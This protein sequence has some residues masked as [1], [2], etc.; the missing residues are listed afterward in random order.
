MMTCVLSAGRNLLLGGWLVCALALPWSG[1]AGIQDAGGNL[2]GGGNW[3]YTIDPNATGVVI[4]EIM[5][6]PASENVLEEYIEL[7]NRGAAAVDLTGWRFSS[8]V[9]F[10]FPNLTIAPGGYLV[11][12]ADLPTFRAKYPTVSNV[13]GGWTGNL[14]NTRE[15]IDLDDATGERIDSVVYADEGDWGER[16]LDAP[17]RGVR[18]WIWTAAHDGEGN[19]AE[20]LNPDLSNDSGQNWAPSLV[21]EGT[22]GRSN[23]VHTNNIPPLLL[24]VRHFPAVPRSTQDVIVTGRVVDETVAGTTVKLQHRVDNPSPVPFSTMLMTDDGTGAD[25]SAGDGVYTAR[26]PAQPTGTVVEFYLEATDGEGRLRLWPASARDIDGTSLGPVAN[27]LYQ[28]DDSTQ[29]EFQGRQ[30][31]YK[32]IMTEIER[33]RLA[34]IPGISTL[35]GP[36]SQMN[37]TFISLDATGTDVRYLA[38]FRNRGHGTR[39]ADPPNY[40]VNFRSDHLWKGVEALNLN[41]RQVHAQHF[42]SAL[43][44]QAGAAGPACVAVQVRVNNANRAV[45]GSPMFG[46]YAA[47]EVIAGDWAERHVPGDDDGNVYR[48]VRDIAPPDFDYRTLEAYPG[49]AGPEDPSSYTHTWIKETNVSEDDWTDLIGM[50]RVLG[51]NGITPFTTENVRQVID[52]E[53]WVRH[54]AVMNLLGN[55]ETG[56]NS[57]YNDDYYFYRGKQDPRFI[58]LFWD[59]DQILG[60]TSFAPDASIFSATADNGAGLALDRLLHWPDFEPLYYRTLQDL[61]DGPFSAAEFHALIEQTLGDYVPSATR[62][63]MENWMASRRAVVQAAIDGLVPPVTVAPL[64]RLSGVPRSPTPLTSA[65]ITVQGTGVT[66]YRFQLDGAPYG[67]ETAVTQPIQLS[68]L[69]PGTHTLAVVARTADGLWQSMTQATTRTWGVNPAWPSVRLNEVLARNDSALDHAGTSPDVVELYNEGSSTVDLAGLRLSDNPANPGKFTFPTGTTLAPGAY[70]VVFAN[71]PDGTPGFHLG[72]GLSESGEGLYLYHR[73]SNGGGLLDA[74]EFGPQITDV[75]IGRIG[76]GG[77]WLLTQPTPGTANQTQPLGEPHRLRINE[78]LAYGQVSFPDD[79]VEL[80]NPESLPVAL[81]GLFLTDEPNGAPMRHRIADLSFIDAGGFRAFVADGE[82]NDG[83]DHLGFRLAAE[84]GELALFDPALQRIDSIVYGPQSL[85][86]SMGRCPD[87]GLNRRILVTPTP[88]APNL[89]PSDPLPP[90]RVT[91][92]AMA[93]TWRFDASGADQGTAWREPGFDDGAWPEGAGLLARESCGCLPEPILTELTFTSP[94]QITFYFRTHFALPP[95]LGASALDITHL[96]DDGAIFYLNGTEIG[97]VNMPPGEVNFQTQASRGVGNATYGGPLNVPLALIQPRDNVLAVEVHQDDTA[98]T[99]LVFGARLDALAVTNTPGW[100]SIVINEVLANNASWEEPDRSLPDWVEILNLSS[101]SVDLADASLTDAASEPRRWVFPPRSVVP[102]FGYLKVRC[103]GAAPTSATNTGFGLRAEGGS[104]YLF[105]RPIDGGQLLDSITYGLQPADWS[106]GRIPDG[107]SNWTL[108]QPTFGAANLAA[109]LAS[110]P[111]PKINEWMAAPDA[112]DDWF[113]I[114]NP[115]PQPMDL[116]GLHLTDRL[117]QPDLHRLPPLSFLG[118]GV[119]G[120]QRFIA[121]GNT[122]AGAHHVGFALNRAGDSLGLATGDATAYLDTIAFGPQQTSVSQ[123]RFP[124]GTATIVSFPNSATPGR[125]N[126]LPLET[127]VVNEVLTHSDPPLEDAVEFHNLSGDDLD[128][129]GWWISDSETNFKKY[130]IPAGSILPANGFSVF[131]EHQFNSPDADSPFGFSSARGDAVFL[132]QTDLAGD[133]TGYRATARFGPSA[134]GV[135]FGRFHT[136]QGP[137]FAAMSRRTFG[138]DTPGTVE[139]FR[140]GSG[141]ANAAVQIGPIVISEIMYAPASSTPGLEFL[142]LRNLAVTNVPLYDPARPANTWRLRSGVDFDFPSGTSLSPG[143]FLLVVAFDPQTDPAAQAIFEAE[144]GIGTAMVGPYSGNLNDDGEALELLRPD[145][146]Q[147]TPGPDFG[148]VPYI[149]VD[150]V[151]YQA[152]IPWPI[153]AAGSGPSLQKLDPAFYGDDPVHWMAATATPGAG[154]PPAV[155]TDGDGM[156]DHWELDH[157]LDPDVDDA[158]LD[159]DADG[160]TNRDEYLAGTDPQDPAS[161]LLMVAETLVD[162]TATLRFPVVAGQTYTVQYRGSLN[163]GTWL[164]LIDVE[165]Q[166][167]AREMLVTDPNAGT[168]DARYYRLTTPRLP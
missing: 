77:E 80:H 124:D 17:D 120:Y 61:L 138:I 72:F 136:S 4:S 118:A 79:F 66:H 157:S 146:P 163:S 156:P 83:P 90:Q 12:A 153:S 9:Q 22:P 45:S 103:D 31:V 122:G 67:P 109:T 89:C 88:G 84:Q 148:L 133:L 14:S 35:Q 145:P 6:H 63:A 21:L 44:R 20:L 149:L 57:G 147:T 137:H 106:V 53:Q 116:S 30:P 27:L 99:D 51:P 155:D 93:H 117:D 128:L 126:Y 26:L 152:R 82:P 5:Y 59:L 151:A 55:A 23:S 95:G 15:D 42:G 39:R 43:A 16:V 69:S 144:Y 62:Q 8:G 154:A 127:V 74:V 38:G 150:R 36:N 130:L 3:S 129:G 37:G 143:A 94:Q 24:E 112:G 91:V 158:D 78:W 19:S 47:N 96:I 115:Q 166:T 131:Y 50:L 102:A 28:V 87:G 167:V 18:G 97:R 32:L 68:A 33:S 64:A 49:L 11:V 75:S 41:S 98:S 121:D 13:V 114:H 73:L 65:S 76:G 113:E 56:L 104:V 10:T 54:L 132:S 107:S 25:A 123:G 101:E 81:G 58:L 46:S 141:A 135:S 165:A 119:H 134:N 108:T 85:E 60:I 71:D 48:T 1:T 2:F 92:V 70:L 125:G 140:T 105:G 40:R 52:V 164:R 168:G 29:N 159:A 161:V 160:S 111:H 139:E 86:I 162:G 100:A 110:L 7:F 34:S 142:E